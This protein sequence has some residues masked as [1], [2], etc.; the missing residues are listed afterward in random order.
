VVAAFTPWNFPAATVTRKIAPALV[1]GNT[2]VV[3]PSSNTPLSALFVAEA[4]KRAGLPKG[5]LNVVTGPGDE[6]GKA[7]IDHPK[8]S[9]VTL[10]GSTE[11]GKNVLAR[12]AAH[13]S[14]CLL[15][16]GGKAPVIVWHDA[17]LEW[18]A[19]ATVWAR[20][21]NAGQACIAAERC[22]VHERVADEFG[23]KVEALVR[24]LRVGPGLA[25]E[26]DMGPLY[27]PKARDKIAQDVREATDQGARVSVGGTIP[28]EGALARGAFYAPTV[29]TGVDN[30]N[31]A[32]RE[33]IF[34]PV[35]PLLTYD[36]FDEA[37]RRANESRYGLSSYVF[38]RDASLA[39]RA[40]RELKY[41]ET[42][43]NRVGPES[44][45]GYHTAFRESGLGG[46]GTRYGVQDYLQLK[47]VYSDWKTP[48]RVPDYFLPYRG[49]GAD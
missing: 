23:G 48:H 26:V 16:L 33:E 5:V 13:V 34:G 20:Y 12:S 27:S 15:E 25:P 22:F 11:S 35:L 14:K 24:S 19:R 38:T 30:D 46:E 21:W 31:V 2:M 36:D 47:S 45:Q 4:L 29:L 1:G 8:C 42:Y 37:I 44:P 43:V 3:K 39:E 32:S 40:A 28:K 49:R 17:D 10:T 7:L 9:T 18:A 41:G 6:I